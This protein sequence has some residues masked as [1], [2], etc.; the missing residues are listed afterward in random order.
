MRCSRTEK[1][2][3][4]YL[5]ISLGSG[6]RAHPLNNSAEDRFYSIRD[7]NVF[8]PLTQAMY[9]NYPVVKDA[10]LV[11]VS[12]KFGTTITAD[13]PGWKF[14]LPPNEKVL[15][16]SRTF[17]D[18][19]YFVSFEPQT[20]SSDPCQAGLSVNRLYR[21]GVENGDPVLAHDEPVPNSPE[22]I[23]ASRVTTLE[24]GGIAPV[25]VFLF[26]T[27]WG[28]NGYCTGSECPQPDPVTC[29]GVEC[30]DPGFRNFP[31][32]TL[33]TQDGIE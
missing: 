8:N 33:W 7:A 21:V 11:E 6:Y 24:Q 1:Q 14:T 20:L 19:I 12:G 17:D 16:Q 18:A 3:R 5:S 25:P 9:D 15:S 32:R 28:E 27:Y 23:D 4:R 13:Q 29:I 26:P 10:D 22:E 31:V 2:A 30:F